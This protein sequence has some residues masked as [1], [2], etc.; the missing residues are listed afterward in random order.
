MECF[1]GYVTQLILKVSETATE[2]QITR[3]GE[4]RE[5]RENKMLKMFTSMCVCGGGLNSLA[6]YCVKTAFPCHWVVSS[7][8][9][10]LISLSTGLSSW[11]LSFPS[12]QFLFYSPKSTQLDLAPNLSR[13]GF[14]T[15]FSHWPHSLGT[16]HLVCVEKFSLNFASFLFFVR[17]SLPFIYI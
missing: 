10:G 8:L 4:V 15:L 11:G 16:W 5:E 9:T 6:K 7:Q 3:G 14:L 2:E 13:L 12:F 17:D 1:V